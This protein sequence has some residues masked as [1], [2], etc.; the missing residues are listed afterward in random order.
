[1]ISLSSPISLCLLQPKLYIFC[2]LDSALLQCSLIWS[3][4]SIS[5]RKLS[6]LN[7]SYLIQLNRKS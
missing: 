3:V 2:L 5:G 6:L 7:A 1:M 4:A